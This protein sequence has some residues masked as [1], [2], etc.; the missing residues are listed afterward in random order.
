MERGDGFDI[1]R[2]R[3]ITAGALPLG[4]PASNI[5]D[6]SVSDA[7]FQSLNG[8]PPNIALSLSQKQPIHQILT[9][10]SN[11][12]S[13]GSM[14]LSGGLPVTYPLS[15]TGAPPASPDNGQLALAN[16]QQQTVIYSVLKDAWIG[17]PFKAD[18]GLLQGPFP[19]SGS[20]FPGEAI[21]LGTTSQSS[22]NF[23]D[24]GA[25]PMRAPK[26]EL[27]RWLISIEHAPG[28]DIPH[29]VFYKPVGG[30]WTASGIVIDVLT[31]A[32]Q[33]TNNT[34]TLV[35]NEGDLVVVASSNPLGYTPGA[36]VVS[37]QVQPLIEA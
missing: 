33:G 3:R 24:V 14:G 26:Q 25:V 37:C 31:G 9:G 6:G 4:I 5:A 18:I 34:D 1:E 35:L 15:F 27:S 28:S 19:G 10:I 2:R 36:T 17:A 13:D 30:S 16:G 12:P 11:L 20:W 23:D 32:T 22:S 21:G 8:A 29:E 7:E